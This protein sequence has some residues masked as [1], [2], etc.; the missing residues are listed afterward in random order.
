MEAASTS[1]AKKKKRE[2]AIERARLRL[3]LHATSWQRQR[4]KEK[5]RRKKKGRRASQPEDPPPPAKR[6]MAKRRKKKPPLL[7]KL[8]SSH[9]KK[10]GKKDAR[11]RVLLHPN[12]AT[13]QKKKNEPLAHVPP[14][15]P[16]SGPETKKKACFCKEKKRPPHHP[17][18]QGPS[19][20]GCRGAVAAAVD[21]SC[22]AR[23]PSKTSSAL[24]K[25]RLKRPPRAKI[26]VPYRAKCP[27]RAKGPT[28]A[29]ILVPHP[30]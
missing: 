30:S 18:S 12:L 24:P 5:K 7:S 20:P 27:T 13:R 8:P 29:K 23:Y 26:K 11:L 3:G 28:R 22:L 15:G 17:P 6:D 21:V 10:K 2:K 9:M 16:T 25:L 4:G 1:D 19:A 14:H